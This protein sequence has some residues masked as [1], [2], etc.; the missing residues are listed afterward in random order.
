MRHARSTPLMTG[1]ATSKGRSALAAADTATW[2]SVTQGALRC[3]IDADPKTI[4]NTIAAQMYFAIV[5][6]V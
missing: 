2:Y 6:G 4:A 1:C 3:A 5:S